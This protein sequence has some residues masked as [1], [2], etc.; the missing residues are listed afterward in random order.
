MQ[1]GAHETH[2]IG[3]DAPRLAQHHAEHLARGLALEVHLVLRV[4][5]DFVLV[6]AELLPVRVEELFQLLEV[7][8]QALDVCG[9]H[10][11]TGCVGRWPRKLILL[12]STSI[13]RCRRSSREL[14][15]TSCSSALL[16]HQQSPVAMPS[17]SVPQRNRT[18]GWL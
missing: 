9:N 7:V 16:T 6:E 5:R 14:L 12:V 4:E 3:D 15:I 2:E 11:A 17:S 18:P 10:A 13:T 8:G 1:A